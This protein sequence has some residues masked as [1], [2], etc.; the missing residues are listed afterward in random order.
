MYQRTKRRIITILATVFMATLALFCLTL[1]PNTY[2]AK[3]ELVAPTNVKTDALGFLRWDKVSGATGYEWSYS[4]DGTSY[5][6]GGTVDETEADI[7]AAIT[8]AIKLARE[9]SQ[10]SATLNLK[11]KATGGAE[12]AFTYTFDKYI[13]YGYKTRDIADVYAG[14]R[15][16]VTG[17]FV[18]TSG[19]YTNELMTFGF[20]VSQFLQSGSTSKTDF[21]V[22]MLN[23]SAADT[24]VANTTNYYY[25]LRFETHG[26]TKIQKGGTVAFNQ[27]IGGDMVVNQ[28]SYFA[29]GVFDTYN[30]L[31]G[32]VA[33][34]TV[35]FRRTDVVNGEASVVYATGITTGKISN[36]P[37]QTFFTTTESADRPSHLPDAK[38]HTVVNDRTE[39]VNNNRTGTRPKSTFAIS[40][41]NDSNIK[42]V[43][44]KIPASSGVAM[45]T[46]VHYDNITGQ[47][48][49]TRVENATGYEWSY[50]GSNVWTE[51]TK[52]FIPDGAVATA[53]QSAKDSGAES[54]RF[55]VRAVNDNGKS[56]TEYLCLDLTAFYAKESA[57]KDISDIHTN[58]QDP[59]ATLAGSDIYIATADMQS[60]RL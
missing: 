17:N 42:T 5:T 45:P 34:E 30:V 53:I 24:N 48:Q 10:T 47:V 32:S 55:A 13:N 1:M 3:A 9:N 58:L 20:S 44:G 6:S 25:R 28:P 18:A 29:V 52:E 41:A 51:A 2:S 12:T 7:S 8:E 60:I 54:V 49:W 46:M 11:V 16:G 57:L 26:W 50:A 43:S 4:T 23:S 37:I 36:N 38:N 33:G 27:D 14:A 35:Y 31:D 40:S 21:Y 39:T 59:T 19:L 15:T 22:G 56:A